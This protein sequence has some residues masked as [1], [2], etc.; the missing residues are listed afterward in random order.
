MS[1]QFRCQLS[2]R[3]WITIYVMNSHRLEVCNHERQSK[4]YKAFPSHM[5]HKAA[6]YLNSTALSQAPA[7]AKR[8]WTQGQC[9]TQCACL[10]HVERGEAGKLIRQS[11]NATQTTII[12]TIIPR[13]YLFAIIYGKAICESSL[14]S[15]KQ[16][17]VSAS[18]P[19]TRRPSC[20]T[21]HWVYR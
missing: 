2:Q 15:F 9:V 6:L 10:T 16:K 14:G 20:K 11:P 5:T 13:R 17:S 21:D 8:A 18:W 7:K 4:K 12:I 3:H 19:P 1:S